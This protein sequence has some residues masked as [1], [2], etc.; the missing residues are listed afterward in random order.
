MSFKHVS[1]R[2]RNGRD[3]FEPN[4]VINLIGSAQLK[5]DN[6]ADSFGL[7][8]I[9]FHAAEKLVRPNWISNIIIKRKME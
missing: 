8:S 3:K 2:C 1:Q 4:R 5:S 6:D 9:L 7:L